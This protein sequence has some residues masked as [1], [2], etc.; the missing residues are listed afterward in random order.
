[1]YF[2]KGALTD[3]QKAELSRK[4]T[5]L[6]VKE[7]KHPQ[8]YTCHNLRGSSGELDGRPTNATRVKGEA[9]GGEEVVMPTVEELREKAARR[10]QERP[11][12]FPEGKPITVARAF[13]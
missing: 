6:I 3:E 8:H 7:A 5:D 10:F 4:V 2:G 11:P 13:S 1:M 12:N 9:Q